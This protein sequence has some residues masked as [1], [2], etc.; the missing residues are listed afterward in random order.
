MKLSNNN[1]IIKKQILVPFFLSIGWPASHEWCY[2]P[3]E[4]MIDP[5]AYVWYQAANTTHP[6]VCWENSYSFEFWRISQDFPFPI[7]RAGFLEWCSWWTG[8][9]S[10]LF[11]TST[12]FIKCQQPTQVYRAHLDL[13]KFWV[14]RSICNIL[15]LCNNQLQVTRI[16]GNYSCR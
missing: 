13:H 11:E 7:P 10:I 15:V 1:S 16:T 3:G 8:H 9:V 6:W 2:Q 5:G 14:N 4:P 12:V